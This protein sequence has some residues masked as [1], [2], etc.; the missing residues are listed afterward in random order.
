M[1]EIV[2]DSTLSNV[3]SL[4]RILD[5][6]LEDDESPYTI[7]TFLEQHKRELPNIL[8]Y[9]DHSPRL[10]SLDFL[11]KCRTAWVMEKLAS[12]T[13]D[14]NDEEQIGLIW[15][16]YSCKNIPTTVKNVFS[17]NFEALLRNGVQ[18]VYSKGIGQRYMDFE[19]A[20]F[21]NYEYTAENYAEN[22]NNTPISKL[23]WFDNR[24]HL[25]SLFAK[26][27][28]QA[29]VFSMIEPTHQFV[30]L[31]NMPQHNG[32]IWLHK[33]MKQIL[34]G[35][36]SYDVKKMVCNE[37]QFRGYHHDFKIDEDIKRIIENANS[38]SEIMMKMQIKGDFRMFDWILFWV[39]LKRG[40]R[41]IQ[42]GGKKFEKIF[43]EYFDI[44]NMMSE[45]PKQ[46]TTST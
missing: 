20:L 28:F 33:G 10:F 12:M 40:L 27:I 36:F 24:M 26:R 17:R 22:I 38:F 8:K 14:F 29:D 43:K 3:V 35:D 7:L 39:L 6:L 23:V 15:E 25:N 44:S 5:C 1:T 13:W 4:S 37:I 45:P 46:E 9:S 18:H 11:K 31:N 30:L 16:I 2:F 21:N 34:D 41:F 42:D 19:S 32:R